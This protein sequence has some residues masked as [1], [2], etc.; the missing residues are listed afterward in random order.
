[1]IAGVP[2]AGL[3]IATAVAVEGGMPMVY[4]RPPKD[5][6]TGATVEGPYQPGDEVVV[7]DDVATSGTSI[8]EAAASLREAGLVV[9]DAVVLVDRGGGAREALRAEDITLHPVTTLG[10]VVEHLAPRLD[11]AI[12][13]AARAFLAR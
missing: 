7:V 3:P 9:R 8:L 10:A 6:G 12:L 2:L 1:M 13:D 5:H 11:P 4:P